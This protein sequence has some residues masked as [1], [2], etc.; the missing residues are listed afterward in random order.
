MDTDLTVPS[1]DSGGSRVPGFL[2]GPGGPIPP[3]GP[4]MGPGGP[5]PPGGPPMGPGG[6]PIH[7]GGLGGTVN[8][9]YNQLQLWCFPRLCSHW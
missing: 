8:N 7:P 4:P 1:S 9:I 6:P 3:G 2:G 5:I